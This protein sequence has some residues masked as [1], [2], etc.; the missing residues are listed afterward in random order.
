[1]ASSSRLMRTQYIK[2]ITYNK[3]HR[4]VEDYY[5]GRLREQ[6]L[7]AEAER[8]LAVRTEGRAQQALNHLRNTLPQH[9]YER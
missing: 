9:A 6:P 1:M 2:S 5:L 7:I 4:I 8:R 3:D